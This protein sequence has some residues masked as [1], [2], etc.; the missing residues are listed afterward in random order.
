[1][2]F[3]WI[4]QQFLQKRH[5]VAEDIFVEGGES[6]NDL[7]ARCVTARTLQTAVVGAVTDDGLRQ[8]L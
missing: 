3:C 4:F 5:Q 1:M 8:A 6:G 7:F 2:I